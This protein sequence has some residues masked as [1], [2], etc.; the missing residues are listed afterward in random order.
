MCFNKKVITALVAAG[1][2]V[3]LVAPSAFYAALPLLILAACPLSM[4]V[5]MR[6]MNG[7]SGKQCSPSSTE[8]GDAGSETEADE[9]TRLRAEVDQLRAERADREDRRG[10]SALPPEPL[11]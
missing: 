11:A 4:I 5:M 3:F 7:M 8:D 2:G 1:A 9:V 10:A 6:G